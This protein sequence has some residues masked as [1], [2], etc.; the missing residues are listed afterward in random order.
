MLNHVWSNKNQKFESNNNV[1]ICSWFPVFFDVVLRML[2][3]NDLTS[4]R[5]LVLNP[6]NSSKKSFLN[7]WHPWC[8]LFQFQF[9]WKFSFGSNIHSRFLNILTIT[10]SFTIKEFNVSVKTSEDISN[11]TDSF[12]KLYTSSLPN[13]FCFSSACVLT[14]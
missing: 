14:K 8:L 7:W 2:F 6:L 10:D 5:N 12:T 13:F 9:P 1:T 3:L 11:S 4:W